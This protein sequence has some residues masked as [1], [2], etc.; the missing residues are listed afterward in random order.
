M[1][2]TLLDECFE[3]N[4]DV[5]EKLIGGK[6]K[7]LYSNNVIWINKKIKTSVEKACVLAE[8]LGH[9]YTTFGDI[10]DQSTLINRKQELRAR[11]WAYE[12]L[13]PLN[14]I[15]QA[16]KAGVRTSYELAEF[17]EV[18]EEFLHEALSRYRSKYGIYVFVD[19]RKIILD[20]L[21]VV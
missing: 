8:E 7:G 2:E 15:V 18:T 3:E 11:W 12:K 5:Y 19:D 1:Y 21:N 13:I 9:H 10:L 14:K 4:I 17:L 20:P 16:Q 6:I